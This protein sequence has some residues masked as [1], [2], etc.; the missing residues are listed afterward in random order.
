M[1]KQELIFQI[2]RAQTEKSG[3]I[4]SEGLLECLPDGFGFLRAPEYNYLPARTTSTS[5]LRRSASSTCAPATTVSGQV[6]PPKGWRALLRPHTRTKLSIFRTPRSPATKSSSTT[7]ATLPQGRLK[8]ETT[9]R[10]PLTGRVL[11]LLLPVGKGQRGL[12]NAPPRTGKTDAAVHRQFRHR[13]SS[14]RGFDRAP[15]RRAS[16]EVTD[17]QRTREG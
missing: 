16:G 1:R 7:H 4:F 12:I 8:M 5:P 13:Q 9:R 11:D 2:L 17:M 6:R 14:G 10:T 3:L 15:H